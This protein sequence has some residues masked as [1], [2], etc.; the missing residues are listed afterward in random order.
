MNGGPDWGIF[1]PVFVAGVLGFVALAA[2]AR[3]KQQ[4]RRPG[5]RQLYHEGMARDLAAAQAKKAARSA[6][7]QYNDARQSPKHQQ[8]HCGYCGETVTGS[9]CSNCGATA[10]KADA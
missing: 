6:S 9:R 1:I 10:A 5:L 4:N 2:N 7:S 8:L 3:A